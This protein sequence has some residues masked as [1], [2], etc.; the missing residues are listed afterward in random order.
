MR[1]EREGL[2]VE[3]V[4]HAFGAFSMAGGGGGDDE[5]YESD[6]D[7]S[8]YLPPDKSEWTSKFSAMKA[9]A[10]A[11]GNKASKFGTSEKTSSKTADPSKSEKEPS[12]NNSNG[13]EDDTA[14]TKN[15]EDE[16]SNAPAHTEQQHDDAKLDPRYLDPNH[17]ILLGRRL[18]FT[19]TRLIQNASPLT[20]KEI[21]MYDKECGKKE[22]F[23]EKR[24]AYVVRIF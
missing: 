11:H 22:H 19:A 18:S 24:F 8:D 5:G 13:A 17:Q 15:A 7:E 6:T 12:K 9:K 23:A 4:S 2:G 20:P 10:K 16:K 21:K 3:H 14:D 1:R